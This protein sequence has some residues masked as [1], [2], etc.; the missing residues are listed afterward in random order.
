MINMKKI[1]QCLNGNLPK[2]PDNISD[3]ARDLYL[4]LELSSKTSCRLFLLMNTGTIEGTWYSSSGENSYTE[5][6]YISDVTIT[7][8]SGTVIKKASLFVHIA[9]I[10]AYSLPEYV[11]VE[12]AHSLSP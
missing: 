4:M 11:P 8:N 12:E 9:E 2:M 6:L 7:L 3:K 1:Q 10:V 5:F